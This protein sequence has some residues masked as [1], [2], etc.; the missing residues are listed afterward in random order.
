MD[1][2]L[3]I[4]NN[5]KLA[6]EHFII[7]NDVITKIQNTHSLLLTKNTYHF[8][9]YSLDLDLLFFNKQLIEKEYDY[10]LNYRK[11][12]LNKLYQDLFILLKQ[13]IKCL[14]EFETSND[15]EKDFIKK[16]L[17]DISSPQCITDIDTEV[18][19]LCINLI[20][21]YFEDYKMQIENFHNFI[22]INCSNKQ[23]FDIK[24]MIVNLNTQH[25]KMLIEYD[26][27]NELFSEILQSHLSI[28]IKFINKLSHSV[29]SIQESNNE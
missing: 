1:S 12:C 29:N 9:N 28:S 13:V 4:L 7:Y 17:R 16:K 3:S 8:L 11:N 10:F 15:N 20:K 25:K 2:T 19:L 14:Y 27:L 26:G 18:I 6:Q 22:E 24:N 23:N 5:Y 21:D